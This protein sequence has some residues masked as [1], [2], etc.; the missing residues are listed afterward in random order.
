MIKLSLI[1]KILIRWGIATKNYKRYAYEMQRAL[2][3]E[4]L[5][6]FE[7]WDKYYGKH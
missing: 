5:D 4:H 3:D 7:F 6:T 1:D 2:D